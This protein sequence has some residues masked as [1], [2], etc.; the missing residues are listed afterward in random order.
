M[1]KKL[2]LSFPPGELTYFF[3]KTNNTFANILTH[4]SAIKKTILNDFLWPGL[5]FLGSIFN[6][7]LLENFPKILRNFK[8]S[9]PQRRG[10]HFR[11]LRTVKGGAPPIPAKNIGRR[12]E[13]SPRKVCTL[14]VIT[15]LNA[16][17]P[18]ELFSQSN[19]SFFA[20]CRRITNY[21]GAGFLTT[22][23]LLAFCEPQKRLKTFCGTFR[24]VKIT[25]YTLY[26]AFSFH[27]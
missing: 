11:G 17:T 2:R 18:S 26:F 23:R 1:T 9:A 3:H 10:P 20:I 8:S 14:V 21:E 27:F 25:L 15:L 7:F 4:F 12:Q 13:K 22:F 5:C 19:S 24:A 16:S 6:V